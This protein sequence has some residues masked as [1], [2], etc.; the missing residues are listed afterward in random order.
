[1]YL[2]FVH[3]HIG[4]VG[5]A[6]LGSKLG[7]LVNLTKLDLPGARR[8]GVVRTCTSLPGAPR[9]WQLTDGVS[10]VHTDNIIGIQGMVAL[11]PELGKLVNLTELYLGGTCF[12]V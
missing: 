9:A 11:A 10:C 7:K 4:P 6:A 1:M 12:C 5:A 2:P 8:F 3:I